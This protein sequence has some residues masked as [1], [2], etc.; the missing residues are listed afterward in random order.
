MTF[1]VCE[2]LGFGMAAICLFLLY[3]YPNHRYT[4]RNGGEG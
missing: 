2:W 4:K 3:R 1:T